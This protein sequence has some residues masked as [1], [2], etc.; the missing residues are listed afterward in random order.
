[1]GAGAKNLLRETRA[2]SLAGRALVR[3]VGAMIKWRARTWPLAYADAGPV[4]ANL[5][6][7]HLIWLLIVLT[8]GI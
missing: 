4:A 8:I 5:L 6:G 7:G 2:P 1:M 3:P